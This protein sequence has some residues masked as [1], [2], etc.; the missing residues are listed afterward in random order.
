MKKILIRTMAACAVCVALAAG[1]AGCRRQPYPTAED[2]LA[3][4]PRLA[5][6]EERHADDPQWREAARFLLANLPYYYTYRASE[7]EPHLKVYELFGSGALSLEEVQDSVRRLYGPAYPGTWTPVRD[8]DMDPALLVENMEWAFK[9][10]REQPW[11]KNVPF[12]DFCE[13]ILPYRIKDEPLKPWREKLYRKYNPMLDSIRHLPEAED[14]LFAA[15]VLLDSVSREESHFHA[16]LGYGPHVGPDL[17]EWRSGNCRELT[18]RLT[19]IFRAVGIPCGCD[20]MPLRGDA[21]VAHYWNFVLDRYGD[22]YYMYEKQAIRPVRDFFGARSKIYRQTF[23]VNKTLGAWSG[24]GMEQVWPGFRYPCVRDVTRLYGGRQA[25]RLV[26]PREKCLRPVRHDETVYLCVSTYLD[27]K[28][29]AWTRAAGDLVFGDV[30]G[31]CVYLLAVYGAGGLEPVSVPFEFNRETGGIYFFGASEPPGA[32]TLV[33]KFN[34]LFEFFPHRM[35]GGVFEG[36][37]YADFRRADTLFT[38]GTLPLRLHNVAFTPGGRAYRYVR[39]RGPADSH[40]DVSEVAFYRSRNDTCPLRG[41]V[42]GTP[43]GAEGEPDHDYT[44]V[45]DGDHCTSFHYHLPTGGWSGL[46]LGSPQ[47][48][49]KIVYTPRNR[50]NYILAGDTYELFYNRQGRWVSAGRRVASAD[51]LVYEVPGDAL[52]FLKNHSRGKDER[53][54]EYRDGIQT[55]W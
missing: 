12:A 3:H 1:L 38:V 30:S 32:V 28:P 43:N 29:V 22:S 20:Y 46:D 9:V 42:I 25:R 21:N 47:P 7:L 34:Q 49:E 4:N 35:V 16:S 36:S 45:Y 33:N 10:W 55:Y 23:S 54:F 41:R 44:N 2:T 37:R 8:W 13:Y 48:V 19:Y 24:G 15:R 5:E 26:I 51:S 11:G 40:C 17:V 39:Y 31:G 27:W 18:D 14:P 53:I 52:M 6:V 50:D